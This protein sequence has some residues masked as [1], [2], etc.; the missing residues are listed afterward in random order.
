MFDEKFK[1]IISMFAVIL[2]IYVAV[3][4][5][6][7]VQEGRYIGKEINPTNTINV[8]ATGE[9]FAA[10]DVANFSVSVVKEAK[11]AVEAQNQNAEAINK[12]VKFL[13]D[14]GIEDKDIKTSGYN[15]YPKYDYLEHVGQVFRSYEA[16]QSLDVKVRKIDDAG[17]ILSG[18]VAMGANQVGG[19]NLAIDKEDD[20]KRAARQAAI[21]EAKQKAD[22]LVKDLGVSLGR[23]VSFSESFG[24]IPVP[25]YGMM[26]AEGVGGGAT[27]PDIPKGENK[28]SVSVSLT[29]EIK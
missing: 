4:A 24:G 14:S 10:P 17:K 19:I 3:L 6:N 2:S 21:N 23:L 11:T 16:T 18:V 15:I 28:I 26:K 12:I 27:A 22:D 29:Y 25:I 7:A 1:K 9:V 13:K 20:L 8:S 5:Y